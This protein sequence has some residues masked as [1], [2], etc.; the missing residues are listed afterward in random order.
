[1]AVATE[2]TAHR[3][4]DIVAG[5]QIDVDFPISS[6]AE[7]KVY[8]GVDAELAVLNVDYTIQQLG[9][10]G[11]F[12]FKLTPLA[13]LLE[14][15]NNLIAANPDEINAITVRR[16]KNFL[17]SAT[18]DFA[19]S[20]SWISREFDATAMRLQQLNEKVGRAFVLAPTFVGDTEALQLNELV[21]N[22]V[23]VVNDEGDALEAGPTVGDIAGAQ[24]AAAL[25]IAAAEDAVEAMLAATALLLNVVKID[26]PTQTISDTQRANA[27]TNVGLLP[28]F[29]TL[30]SAAAVDLGF[31]DLVTV[32][33]YATASLR[34]PAKYKKVVSEPA[35][36]LKFQCAGGH[37]FEIDDTETL[38]PAHGGAKGVG[39]ETAIV[40]NII[41]LA[42]VR[43]CKFDGSRAP[44][45][46]S[47]INIS[48]GNNFFEI[49]GTFVLLGVSALAQT[50]LCEVTRGN[51]G[52][53]GSIVANA[54]YKTNYAC[55]IWYHN[56]AQ[57]QAGDMS[58]LI[59]VGALVG[60]RMGDEAYGAS[61]TS[62]TT[63]PF[64]RTY[65]CPVALQM[66]GY[67]TF[68]TIAAP[69]VLSG[70]A[71][72]GDAAWAA[73]PR[74]AI[75]T[76][77]VG[78]VVVL[79]GEAI[80]VG[81][82]LATD[83]M[84]DMRPSLTGGKLYYG[85]VTL[86]GVCVETGGPLAR[87]INPSGYVGSAPSDRPALTC[88]GCFG[89]HSQDNAP[90]IE[91]A[92]D[93]IGNVVWIAGNMWFPGG[94]RTQPN[95]KCNSANTRVYVDDIGFGN[96]FKSTLAGVVGGVQYFSLRNIMQ[97]IGL[98]TAGLAAGANLLKFT[99]PNNAGDLAK[100]NPIYSA[101]TG[102]LTVPPGGFKEL[103]IR[104]GVYV[105]GITGRIVIQENGTEVAGG[106]F[107]NGVGQVQVA[108]Y[109]A[110]AGAEY[111]VTIAVDTGAGSGPSASG[112]LHRLDVQ[113]SR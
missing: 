65:G 62:E 49:V 36:M 12:L 85:R 25:A 110:T 55:G 11:F 76:K 33:R 35:H 80:Q 3:Y 43:G 53:S 58:K 97:W 75:V 68:I 78:G 27:L 63:L 40:Q 24:S 39:D 73:L 18:P 50:A 82:G 28:T 103:I 109:E 92:A 89:F 32:N 93:Y 87:I 26:T 16:E 102:K 104:A 108:I 14:K 99:T 22:T 98:A 13:S 105:S 86:I 74:H 42:M 61:V 41:D 96:G 60:I 57:I 111:T 84:L 10:V 88:I 64:P 8:Y 51:F 4:Y 66:E 71:F 59:A 1:M 90:L 106:P 44:W 83:S 77:G 5:V 46:V 69:P 113:A 21:P 95:I 19:K 47:K 100:F 101:A 54:Q 94:S 70:D 67:N 17:T 38:S 23:L 56:D 91:T 81:S 29:R 112:F 107:V 72:G 2:R 37:W 31:A 34:A 30:A 15:I 7:A 6:E 9:A 45:P 20:P 48:T 79:G 52:V